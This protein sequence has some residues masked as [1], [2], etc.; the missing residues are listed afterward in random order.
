MKTHDS[1]R[2]PTEREQKGAG[3]AIGGDCDQREL[4]KQTAGQTWAGDGIGS[5]AH[6][7]ENEGQKGAQ[8]QAHSRP[9]RHSQRTASHPLA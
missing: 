3:V 7:L 8:Q 2:L 1:F 6:H 5:S 9:Y 4:D